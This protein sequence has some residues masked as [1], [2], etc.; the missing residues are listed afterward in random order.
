MTGSTEPFFGDS[1]IQIIRGSGTTSNLL[2]S[3]SSNYWVAGLS[4]TTKR[5]ILQGDS[6]SLLT[7]G[8]THSTT[9][10]NGLTTLLDNKFD[11]SG[12]TITNNVTIT[13]T[14]S[15]TTLY[16]N[17]QFLTGLVTNDFY[18]TGGTFMGTTLTLNRQNG[19]VTITGFTSGGGS[20][21]F[22]GGTISG[23]LTLSSLTGTTDRMLEVDSTGFVS[24]E[25]TIISAYLTSGST[26]ANLL[27][28]TNNWGNKVYSGTTIT[29]TY[30]GQKHYNSDYLF[31][32]VDNNLWI[33]LS[34]V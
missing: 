22:T 21:T 23:D 34:R 15:A 1:G 2:W 4:G 27:E 14:L 26:E 7:S 29:G 25:R 19:S 12:G 17:G 20:G 8:H 32:A 16:G 30:Q 31:E 10:I 24:A 13:G 3:E 5:I 28:D 33:R 9:D 18:V 6:L 11:K